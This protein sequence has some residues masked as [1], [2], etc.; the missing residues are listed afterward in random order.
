M[1]VYVMTNTVTGKKYVGSTTRS[2]HERKR[3]H[4]KGYH[5]SHQNMF[6]DVLKYGADAFTC[7]ILS[8]H[9]DYE[10]MQASEK[11]WITKLDSINSGYNKITSSQGRKPQGFSESIRRSKTGRRN[12][13]ECKKRMSEGRKGQPSVWKDGVPKWLHR[14][15]LA[16]SSEKRSIKIKCLNNEKIYKN[17]GEAASD[18]GL[19][20]HSIYSVVD[21]RVPSLF[22][23]KFVKV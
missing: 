5:K 3:A 16:G 9:T 1:F 10:S 18:L 8:T 21:G 6:A 17:A 7:E 12:T 4:L 19:K 13:E 20:R 15:M 23:Y 22:G 2:V 11:F 14:K